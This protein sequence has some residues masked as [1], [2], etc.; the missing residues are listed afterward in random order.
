MRLTSKVFALVALVSVMFPPSVSAQA[1]LV[2]PLVLTLPATPRTAALGNAWVAGRNPEVIFYNPAQLVGGGTTAFD[3]SLMH[4]GPDANM[5]TFG[6]AYASGKWSTTLG[7]GVQYLRFRSDPN[8]P[9]PYTEDTLLSR[10]QTKGSSALFVV[11]GGILYKGFRAGASG[12][13]AAESVTSATTTFGQGPVNFS[14]LVADIG[15]SRPIFTGTAAMSIQNIGGDPEDD[16]E[17]DARKIPMPRQVLAGWSTQRGLGPFDVGLTGQVAFRH[18][19]TGFGGGVDI[20]YSWIEGYSFQLRA[21]IRRPETDAA[22]PFSFGAAFTADRL[23]V[24]YGVQLFEG[25]RAA[26]GV[27]IRWR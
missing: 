5:V 23:T 12:K 3:L 19:W 11:G 10:G 2:G 13:F 8:A 9:Y 17:D 18:E 25:G 7:W 4:F 22:H 15:V 6:S 27:T 20:G 24:E 16:P 21:G 1:P 26:N 14:A